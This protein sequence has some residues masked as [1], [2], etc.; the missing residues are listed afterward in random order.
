METKEYWLQIN[1]NCQQYCIRWANNSV[2]LTRKTWK[3]KKWS[4]SL[5]L[6]CLPCF[7]FP[8]YF[9]SKAI[10]RLLR[11]NFIVRNSTGK[12]AK[13][14]K[15]IGSGLK[16]SRSPYSNEPFPPGCPVATPRPILMTIS[17]SIEIR[18][19]RDFVINIRAVD[20]V[21]FCCSVLKTE[22]S[23]LDRKRKLYQNCNKRRSAGNGSKGMKNQM[24]CP[25]RC[26]N[27]QVIRETSEKGTK[28]LQKA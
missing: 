13:L 21:A 3:L 9:L 17:T 22:D 6:F 16:L 8:K 2:F 1:K 20:W 25:K 26:K 24:F 19:T 14:F 15:I 5:T 4:W 23:V 27:V 7:I 18:K 10:F 11:K 28:A 12:L